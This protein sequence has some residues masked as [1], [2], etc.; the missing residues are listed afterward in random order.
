MAER[1]DITSNYLSL[2]ENDRREPS[3]T[4]LR[5]IAS[6]LDVPLGYFLWLSL[7]DTRSEEEADMRDKMDALLTELLRSKR[8]EE[9][10]HE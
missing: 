2:V 8:N 4:L 10:A 9:K 7:G 3:L 5:K 6:E 1:L